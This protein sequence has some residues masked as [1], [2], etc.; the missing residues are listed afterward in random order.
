MEERIINFIEKYRLLTLATAANGIPY[1]CNVF[2]VFDAEAGNFYFMSS[3]DT[4]H[5]SEALA[6]PHVAGTIVSE[7]ISI[8]KIQGMSHFERKCF[9]K[10]Q[11]HRIQLSP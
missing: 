9:G 6:Q 1:C 3:K 7:N 5:I 10:T 2:Y 4:K 8:A 11:L